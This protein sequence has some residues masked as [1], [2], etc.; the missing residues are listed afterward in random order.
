MWIFYKK[1][2]TYDHADQKELKNQINAAYQAGIG[3]KEKN[4]SIEALKATATANITA[5]N[6]TL[7][8]FADLNPSRTLVRLSREK[9][10][11]EQKWLAHY[12]KCIENTKRGYT[13][14]VTAAKAA[15]LIDEAFASGKAD[16]E[17]HI[18]ARVQEER[19]VAARLAA[20]L[21]EKAR[22]E[23]E[24]NKNNNDRDR[25]RDNNDRDRNRDRNRDNNDKKKGE[26]P[27]KVVIGVMALKQEDKPKK[28]DK[29]KVKVFHQLKD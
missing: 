18:K 23:R 8:M 29:Q 11:Q 22:V 20:E 10:D 5:L 15:G 25:N 9:L 24:K 19:A 14:M 4:E 7:E 21:A 13:A 2:L 6:R 16:M 3:G 28:K 1:H 12:N 17:K 27:V 26:Q